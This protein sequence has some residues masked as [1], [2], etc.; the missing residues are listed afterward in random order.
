VL[1]LAGCAGIQTP[2][3]QAVRKEQAQVKRV[4]RPSDRSPCGRARSR[5][6]AWRFS[7]LCRPSTPKSRSRL[8]RLGGFDRTHH[9]RALI[10]RS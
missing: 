3:E 9:H 7:P 5:I 10:A 6:S 4:F 2:G 8:L 1:E